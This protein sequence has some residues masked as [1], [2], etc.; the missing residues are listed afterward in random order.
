MKNKLFAVTILLLSGSVLWA[1][2]NTGTPGGGKVGSSQKLEAGDCVA[3]T[4]SIDLDIN[5]IRARLMNGGDMWWDL[6][7]NAKYEVPKSL[8]G[9]PENPSSLFAGAV[10]IGGVDAQ[11]Q[12]KVAAATY[13]Q[14]GNDFF[15]G[16]L[17][18]NASVDQ[19]T[20]R[21]WDK[22]FEVLGSE[23]DSFLDLVAQG[24]PVSSSKIPKGILN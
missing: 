16:P 20:C 17:D 11:G 18:E 15:P 2:E 23:I 9:Q 5:N 21:Q 19:A 7:N 6:V 22:H 1:K 3:A 14:N 4:S 13:R 10:W 12:L 24:L 8:P